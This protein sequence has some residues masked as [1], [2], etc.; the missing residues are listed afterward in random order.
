MGR[1]GELAEQAR[2]S[3]ALTIT[4]IVHAASRQHVGAS[5]VT[6]RDRGQTTTETDDDGTTRD[7]PV[8]DFDV[9]TI[10]VR[11]VGNGVHA[12]I[13]IERSDVG[14]PWRYEIIPPPGVQLRG[15]DL[16]GVV[17]GPGSVE[18]LVRGVRA[19]MGLSPRVRTGEPSVRGWANYQARR[20]S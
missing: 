9:V 8:R 7:V 16:R 19:S 2:R 10:R 14:D 12:E 6:V 3:T 5:E 20:D 18:D 15:L 1:L 11:S 13:V 4:E 17:V